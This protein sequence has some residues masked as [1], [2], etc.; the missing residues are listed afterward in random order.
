VDGIE[1]L[2]SW[3]SNALM[4]VAGIAMMLM[5]AHIGADIAGKYLFNTP[6]IATLEVVSWYYMVAVVFLP[7]AYIQIHGR[8]LQVE[9]FTRQLSPRK[10]AFLE[11]MVAMLGCI[12]VGI[13]FYLT[14][15]QAIEQTAKGEVQDAT[16]FDLPVWP[17]R[18]LLPAGMG[19][20]TLVLVLQ[21]VRHL[22]FAFTGRGK[23]PIAPALAAGAGSPEPPSA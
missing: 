3:I 19:T 7:V 17:T 22:I 4:V 16:Y 14:L 20:M 15:E 21:A 2:L 12:Y 13:L 8:H 11:G 5:M 23:S 18:W 1:R 10:L 6:V 9:L